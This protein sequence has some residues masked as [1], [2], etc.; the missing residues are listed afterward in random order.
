MLPLPAGMAVVSCDTY[1][2]DETG[3]EIPQFSVIVRG[4]APTDR[5]GFLY[6]LWVTGEV[7]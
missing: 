4:S 1:I 3:R 5:P 7:K 6:E 2:I